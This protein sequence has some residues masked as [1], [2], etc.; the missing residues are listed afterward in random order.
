MDSHQEANPGVHL[1]PLKLVLLWSVLT[2][3]FMIFADYYAVSPRGSST[4]LT[5]RPFIALPIL[6]AVP[7]ILIA[8]IYALCK[9]TRYVGLRWMFTCLAFVV[10][11]IGSMYIGKWIRMGA[12]ASLAERSAPLVEAI[13]RYEQQYEKPPDSLTVLVPE[14]LPEIPRT[15]MGAYPDYNY[16]VITRSSDGN[17]WELSVFT[18][19]GILNFDKFFYYPLQNYPSHLCRNGVERVRDWAYMHE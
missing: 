7:G 11:V 10:L 15:G 1:F 3:A 2:G 9:S 14:F 18:P 19:T 13:K 5:L 8:A 16:R 4:L 17:R 12:F 6:A